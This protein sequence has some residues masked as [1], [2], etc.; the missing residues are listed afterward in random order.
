MTARVS[1]RA[2]LAC[3]L[4]GAPLGCDRLEQ[5]IQDKVHEEVQEEV[6]ETEKVLPPPDAGGQTEAEKIAVKLNLYVEC[7]NRSRDR[8]TEAW[9]RYSERVD[10]TTGVAKNKQT[11][12]VVRVEGELEPC[13]Q[14][15]DQGER[16]E[17]ALPEIE[18]AV[19]AYYGRGL[20]VAGLTQQLDDYYEQQGWKTDDWEKAKT[21]APTFQAAYTA[22][23]E[24][25]TALDTVVEAKKDDNDAKLLA[26][27]ETREG[28]NLRWHAQRVV[29][30]AKAIARCVATEGVKATECDEAH[31]AFATA[32]DEFRAYHD[33]HGAEAEAVF[34]MS[35]FQGAVASYA[36]ESS[37]LM[38]ALHKG[39]AKPDERQRA[40][41]KYNDVV[42]AANNL[43]FDMP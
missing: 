19:K 43:K 16:L 39:K 27:I 13:K 23:D 37:A 2:V 26:L 40:I 29:L 15:V 25:A 17:P 32:A 30:A 10:T 5:A 11:P 38:R 36:T 12:H 28:K 8:I 3:G 9:T 18:A 31:A 35:S 34:W 1:I 6:A 21:I 7:T 20:E 22:W 33:A 24:A 42:N 14:A 4:V 41:D